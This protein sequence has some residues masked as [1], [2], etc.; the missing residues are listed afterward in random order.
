[1]APDSHYDQYADS[2]LFLAAD[3]HSSNTFKQKGTGNFQS[4]INAVKSFQNDEVTEDSGKVNADS[5]YN[6]N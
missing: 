6:K 1:M 4:E 3:P 5:Y 2:N